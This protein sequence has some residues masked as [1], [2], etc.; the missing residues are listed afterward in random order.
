MQESEYFNIKLKIEKIDE[1]IAK[2]P[3]TLLLSI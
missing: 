3:K 2:T 1:Q